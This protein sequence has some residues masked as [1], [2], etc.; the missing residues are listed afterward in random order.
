MTKDPSAEGSALALVMAGEWAENLA[1]LATG[2]EQ[3]VSV[4]VAAARIP[5]WR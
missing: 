2:L 3:P 4:A 5:W 1:R